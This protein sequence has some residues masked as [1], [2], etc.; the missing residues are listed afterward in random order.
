M[1]RRASGEVSEQQITRSSSATRGVSALVRQEGAHVGGVISGGGD[2]QLT[3]V[4]VR[5]AQLSGP[6]V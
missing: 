5:V 6:G 2:G 1:R 4:H 3:P